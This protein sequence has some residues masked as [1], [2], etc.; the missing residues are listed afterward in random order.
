M[1]WIQRGMDDCGIQSA[2]RGNDVALVGNESANRSNGFVSDLDGFGHNY[3]EEFEPKA[4]MDSEVTHRKDNS[5]V[6][7]GWKRHIEVKEEDVNGNGDV[8][9][10]GTTRTRVAVLTPPLK[11][12]GELDGND[13]RAP[14]F[15][16]RVPPLFNIPKT[17]LQCYGESLYCIS[18]DMLS[19]CASGKTPLDRLISVVAWNISTLRPLMFGVA[20][21]NPILGET[22]HVS[23]GTLNVLLEQVSH[24]PPVSALHATD[25]KEGTTVETMVHG[26]RHL[27]LVNKGET[28]VMDHPNLLIRF[29]PVPGV[30]W[31]G[32]VRIH[33]QES[34]LEAELH[35]GGS[36]FISRR[37]Y[38]RSIKGKVFMSSSMKTIYEINGH[39]DR[40]V[41]V[42]DVSNGKQTVIYDAKE[43]L[44][45]LKTPILKDPERLWASESSVVW[46]EVSKNILSKCWDKAREA[47][48][49]VEE[50]E[51]ELLRE[52]MAKGEIWVP[53]HFTVSQSKES[54]WVCL[55][56]QEWVPTA[57]IVV[58]T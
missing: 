22:H 49:A 26:Q 50:K 31:V 6:K 25:E 41:T 47:K 54:G 36:S 39:W 7:T 11:L 29:L 32:K 19:P 15:F 48:T 14:N 46:A 30:H 1:M 57:P 10:T 33:C 2:P 24:H 53:K 16:Q 28:Y 58:P 35:L 21:Y 52:R 18:K 37:A 38:F 40:V 44:S 43:A 13:Y 34:G 9:G 23:R 17:M 27:K 3:S 56:N 4:L 51:R 42:K 8:I 20:P 55:P 5:E 12:E 45:G